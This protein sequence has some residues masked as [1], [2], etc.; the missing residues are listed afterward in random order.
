MVGDVR[1]RRDSFACC[2]GLADSAILPELQ[3]PGQTHLVPTPPLELAEVRRV[4]LTF[5][6]QELRPEG[7]LFQQDRGQAGPESRERFG[8]GNG[9]RVFAGAKGLVT[10]VKTAVCDD[11]RGGESTPH[12]LDRSLSSRTARAM[13]KSIGV[14]LHHVQVRANTLQSQRPSLLDVAVRLGQRM[15]RARPRKSVR[16][17]KALRRTT[18]P[19]AIRA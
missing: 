1:G 10:A 3:T 9:V 11:E 2:A 15:G 5:A 7:E 18:G 17:S 4:D 13:K 8:L 6:L 14:L 16:L 19:L 12:F